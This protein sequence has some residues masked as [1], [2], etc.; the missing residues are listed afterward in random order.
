LGGH[1]F[2]RT[3]IVRDMIINAVNNRDQS[4]QPLQ[5]YTF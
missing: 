3:P 1:Y 2:N 4:Y 5:V